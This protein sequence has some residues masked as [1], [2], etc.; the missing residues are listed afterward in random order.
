MLFI[1]NQ[2][3][4]GFFL[5][6]GQYRKSGYFGVGI[7]WRFCVEMGWLNFGT[8]YRGCFILAVKE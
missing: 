4:C 7:I 2:N 8:L 1:R 5:S 6:K 3:K